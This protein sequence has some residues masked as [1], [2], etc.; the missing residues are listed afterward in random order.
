ML[1][2]YGSSV[3]IIALRFDVSLDGTFSGC[4]TARMTTPPLFPAVY[5]FRAPYRPTMHAS[6]R[7]SGAGT[8]TVSAASSIRKEENAFAR[9]N[10]SRRY[11]ISI[12]YHQYRLTRR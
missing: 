11:I 5:G 2:W 8:I 6:V 9:S 7:R 12:Q 4:I 3:A 10:A 1:T